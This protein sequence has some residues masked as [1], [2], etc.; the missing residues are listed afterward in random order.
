MGRIEVAQEDEEI[1]KAVSIEEI[2]DVNHHDR[3]RRMLV[4]RELL[5][6]LHILCEEL[7]IEALQIGPA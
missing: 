2:Y 1:V 3:V 7:F 4:L 6:R 5:E